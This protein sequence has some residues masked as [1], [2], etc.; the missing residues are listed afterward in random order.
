M[1]DDALPLHFQVMGHLYR[2]AFPFYRPLYFLYKRISDRPKLA[3]LDR[4]I[5][6]GMVALDVGANIGFYASALSRCVGPVGHVHCFE[7]DQTNFTHL[8]RLASGLPNVTTNQCAVGLEGPGRVLVK[9]AAN[10][11]HRLAAAERAGN[12]HGGVDAVGV[13][14][15]SLDAYCDKLPRVDFIK[16]DI[17]GGEYEALC[18]LRRTLGRFPGLVI[19][20]EYWPYGLRRAGVEPGAMLELIAQC[21]LRHAPLDPH[22]RDFEQ[23]DASDPHGYTDLLLWNGS[24]AGAV[25]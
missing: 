11:D 10:V 25:L 4:L 16:M 14:V 23:L 22:R 13:R 21:G 18:G 5:R 1:K 20:M 8:S 19:I 15:V 3:L 24:S 6:P 12:G 7:P 9:S 17:Q 2:R